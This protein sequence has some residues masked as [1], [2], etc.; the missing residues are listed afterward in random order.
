MDLTYRTT[1]DWGAGKGSELTSAEID[2]NFYRLNQGMPGFETRRFKT[3]LNT[4]SDALRDALDAAADEG[5]GTVYLSSSFTLD[6]SPIEP[7]D[8]VNIVGIHRGITVTVGVANVDVFDL[9]GVEGVWLVGFRIVGSGIA[10]GVE[11]GVYVHGGST[12]CVCN[13]LHISNTR[14]GTQ[15]ESDGNVVDNCVYEDIV[16]VDGVTGGYAILVD[17]AKRVTIR[18]CEFYRVIRHAIYLSAGASFIDVLGGYAKDCTNDVIVI[19]SKTS[20][21]QPTCEG[22]KIEDFNIENVIDPASPDAGQIRRNGVTI[23]GK[24]R[25]VVLC[26]VFVENPKNYG[27]MVVGDSEGI[28]AN[29]RLIDCAVT[30]GSAGPSQAAIYCE[31]TDGTTTA[32][33][34]LEIIRPMIT[35]GASYGIEILNSL[36][37]VIEGGRIAG[38]TDWSLRIGS[39]AT[40]TRIKGTLRD[41]GISV[42]DSVGT[43]DEK[44]RTSGATGTL[45]SGTT[46]THGLGSTPASVQVTPSLARTVAFVTNRTDTTFDITFNLDD[47]T[48]ATNQPFMWEAI[49]EYGG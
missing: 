13:T 14:Y 11:R 21:S 8:F 39:G 32:L 38:T 18:K 30:G 20:L 27:F 49:A 26:R 1:G 44:R 3:A 9:D 7:P 6:G 46:I 48:A 36:N 34:G 42:A 43:I 5:G 37:A 19:Y 24:V 12:R 47:G 16:G 4:W 41:A 28:P 29:V 22:I 33:L 23:S 2:Q 31:G 35:F 15:I 40:G 17:G 10:S 45:A 25:N